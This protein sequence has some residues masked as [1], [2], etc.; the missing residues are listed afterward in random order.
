M[1]VAYLLGTRSRDADLVIQSLELRKK[2]FPGSTVDSLLKLADVYA[3]LKQ[4]DARALAYYQSAL[5]AAP[6][7]SKD[8][9]RQQIPKAYASRL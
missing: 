5:A 4:D 6:V 8:N 7:G 9:V 2:K 1:N 3:N